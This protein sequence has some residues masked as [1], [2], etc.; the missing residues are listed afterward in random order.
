MIQLVSIFFCF[1]EFVLFTENA[2]SYLSDL[3][4][5]NVT[6]GIWKW[7]GGP[8]MSGQLGVYTGAGAQPGGRQD[9]A[10]WALSGFLYLF[11]GYGCD[12]TCTLHICYFICSICN[13]YYRLYLLLE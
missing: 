4:S 8:F 12:T 5:F 1:L 2:V 13:L 6:T 10:M 9:A 11:G 7:V 3:W